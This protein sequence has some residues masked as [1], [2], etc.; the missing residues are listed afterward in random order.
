MYKINI[1][2]TKWTSYSKNRFL[3]SSCWFRKEEWRVMARLQE[4]L[5]IRIMQDMSETLCGIMM[6]IFRL[7][8]FAM[9]LGELQQVAFA[10]L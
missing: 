6:K 5:G 1:K 10:I 3:K 2:L 9:R 8:A 4:R 7:I